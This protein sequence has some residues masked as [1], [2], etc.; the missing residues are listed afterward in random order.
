M[1]VF[2][3]KTILEMKLETMGFEPDPVGFIIDH[4]TVELF[5]SLLLN[6]LGRLQLF[7]YLR[8]YKKLYIL[9]NC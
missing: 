2:L 6:L 9:K 7:L 3:K 1:P 5:D 8:P 4:L